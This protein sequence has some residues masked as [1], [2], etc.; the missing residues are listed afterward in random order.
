MPDQNV[1]GKRE[2]FAAKLMEI[3]N[4]RNVVIKGIDWRDEETQD[5]SQLILESDAKRETFP[6][7]NSDLLTR[8]IDELREQIGEILDSFSL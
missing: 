6:V 3:A 8:P 5:A 7:S 4:Q 1:S 2:Q